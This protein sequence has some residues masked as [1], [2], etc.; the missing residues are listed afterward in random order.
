MRVDLFLNEAVSLTV[1]V[2][3]RVAVALKVGS[4][5]FEGGCD[6]EDGNVLRVALSLLV[7]SFF[8]LIVT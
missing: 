6:F 3:I 5:V 1:G 8:G 2:T 7:A 4:C